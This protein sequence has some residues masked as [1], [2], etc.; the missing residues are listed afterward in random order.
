MPTLDT[1]TSHSQASFEPGVN[2]QDSNPDAGVEHTKSDLFYKIQLS[3]GRD[4]VWVHASDGSTVGRFGRFGIDLHNT[5]T[6]QMAGMPECKLCTHGRPT[7]DDWNLF[8]Q[9][10]QEFYGVDVP[11]DAFSPELFAAGSTASAAT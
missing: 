4:A 3:E 11:A 9:K 10:C 8:R 6:D 2:L 7:S 5:L 1:A